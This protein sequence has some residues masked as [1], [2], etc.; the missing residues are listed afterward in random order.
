MRS[1]GT[2]NRGHCVVVFGIL[3]VG[4]PLIWS[5][6]GAASAAPPSTTA[7]SLRGSGGSCAVDLGEYPGELWTKPGETRARRCL[8]QSPRRR[9]KTPAAG[10]RKVKMLAAQVRQQ[11]SPD[12][13]LSALLSD[14]CDNT[15]PEHEMVE[16]LAQARSAFSPP[17]E[18]DIVATTTGI[19][20]PPGSSADSPFDFTTALPVALT[21]LE[22]SIAGEMP[23][24]PAVPSAAPHPVN[25]TRSSARRFKAPEPA[26]TPT[27]GVVAVLPNTGASGASQDSQQRLSTGSLLDMLDNL[28]DGSAVCAL[29]PN[30]MPSGMVMAN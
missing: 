8:V 29:S 22:Q 3:L 24:P 27:V 13:E 19:S 30:S 28:A 20:P 7:P 12:G 21:E 16:L 11:V 15:V 4:M 2:P 9:V 25:A 26:S 18:Q 6:R 10:A 17:P 23:P 5:R 14:A 1:H